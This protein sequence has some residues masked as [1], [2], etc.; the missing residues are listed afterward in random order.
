MALHNDLGRWGEDIAAQY[1]E[2][3]GWYIRHRDWRYR[4]TDIDLVCIDSDDTTLVFVE[5]KTRSTAD[6]GRPSEA[7]DADKRR[8][9]IMAAWAYR[10]MFRKEN[11]M[12]RYDIISIIGS[13]HSPDIHI[14]HIE[15][16]FSMIDVYEDMQATKTTKAT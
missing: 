13:Q 8:N 9:I 16:A 11:R 12:V 2:N 6:Y 15:D 1:M 3:K 5:V 14:E 10:R 7:V 4:H